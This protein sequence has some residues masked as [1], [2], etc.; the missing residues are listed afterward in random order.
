MTVVPSDL[1]LAPAPAQATADHAAKAAAGRAFWRAQLYQWHWIS[2]ALSLIGLLAFTL[3]GVTLNHAALIKAEPKVTHRM[4]AAPPEVMARLTAADD[5]K[6]P[7]PPPVRVWL[8]R[9]LGA[10]IPA[11]PAEWSPEEVYLALPRPGGDAWV[12][13]DRETRQVE[14]EKTTRGAVA[15]LNDLHKGRNT[16]LPWRVFIDVFAA[17]CTVFSVTGLLLLQIHAKRRA[18]TWP[19]VVGGLAIPV[20]VILL[21]VHL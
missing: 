21:L 20:V 6:T 3:T 19:L 12:R 9:Q 8:E 18:S 5:S 10:D 4:I 7:L 16:G 13:F 17:A 11:E 14:Y 15:L 1:D 2:S